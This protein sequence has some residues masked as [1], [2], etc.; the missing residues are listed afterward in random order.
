MPPRQLS[1][2]VI[3]HNFPLP[4]TEPAK[5]RIG[6]ELDEKDDADVPE[7]TTA[8]GRKRRSSVAYAPSIAPKNSKQS[9]LP[10]LQ[11]HAELA[12]VVVCSF[13]LCAVEDVEEMP[14]IG[15]GCCWYAESSG[16]HQPQLFSS[17]KLFG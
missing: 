14:G 6:P 2:L 3:L 13:L 16:K 17:Q 12:L 10:T 7:K 15:G 1:Q 5:S 4:P 8:S 9:L 11:K